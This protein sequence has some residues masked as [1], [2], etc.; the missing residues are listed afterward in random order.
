MAKRDCDQ[1]EQLKNHKYGKLWENGS[2]GRDYVQVLVELIEVAIHHSLFL[3]PSFICHL[4]RGDFLF[5]RVALKYQ[6]ANCSR[7]D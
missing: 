2:K 1:Q 4:F 5:R 7:E 3:N 6:S